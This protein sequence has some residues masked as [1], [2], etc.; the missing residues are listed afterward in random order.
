MGPQKEARPQDP[1]TPTP[2]PW[3]LPALAE[4]VVALPSAGEI[5][6]LQAAMMPLVGAGLEA[7]DQGFPLFAFLQFADHRAIHGRVA[8]AGLAPQ[9]LVFFVLL[10]AQGAQAGVGLALE[11]LRARGQGGGPGPR[12]GGHDGNGRQGS[13]PGKIGH[14]A[15]HADG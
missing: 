6:P 7:L 5:G 9:L 15:W 8:A 3:S 4:S 11:G 14:G 13:D 1:P 12:E 10:L 2:R